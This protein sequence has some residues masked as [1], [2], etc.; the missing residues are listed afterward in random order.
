MSNSNNTTNNILH[1]IKN[2]YSIEDSIFDIL[3]KFIGF[4][5]IIMWMSICSYWTYTILPKFNIYPSNILL[6]LIILNI[7]LSFIFWRFVLRK[8]NKFK[9]G[10]IGILISL[11]KPESEERILIN[12]E[13]RLIKNSLQ[14]LANRE[15]VS[16]TIKIRILPDRLCP[17]N[18]DAA[19]SLRDKYK[20]DLIIWGDIEHGNM[21]GKAHTAFSN[22]CFS[23]ALPLTQENTQ[24]FTNNLSRI[25]KKSKWLIRESENLND[26]NTLVRNLEKFSSYIIGFAYCRKDPNIALS[27]LKKSFFDFKKE[28]QDI[29]NAVAISNLRTIILDILSWRNKQ[30]E[31]WPS[32]KILPKE[33]E[34]CKQIIAEFESVGLDTEANNTK[35]VM[36]VAAGELGLAKNA[37]AQ[38]SNKVIKKDASISFNYAYIFY[39]EGNIIEGTRFL[40]RS[41]KI[42]KQNSSNLIEQSPN[43]ARWYQDQ[44]QTYPEKIYLNFPLGIIYYDLMGDKKLAK[45]CLKIALDYCLEKIGEDGIWIKIKYN[46]EKRLRKTGR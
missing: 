28:A 35:A 29:D 43:L 6:Q 15:N 33:V 37:L 1:F 9:D 42:L 25:L 31:L 40:L 36:Y 20:S 18:K 11:V 8:V 7:V 45:D 4:I 13:L 34:K 10:E 17:K 14:T 30:L 5:L 32:S 22:T 38:I 44:L 3:D 19:Y 41:I 16:H 2:I 23:Y 12:K 24:K 21:N 27:F 26:R 46:I 39:S